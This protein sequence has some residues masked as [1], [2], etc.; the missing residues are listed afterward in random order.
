M[1]LYLSH[2]GPCPAKLNY[3][4][5]LYRKATK[6][7]VRAPVRALG[8]WSF[9]S[10]AFV[11]LPSKYISFSQVCRVYV[12]ISIYLALKSSKPSMNSDRISIFHD[13]LARP[14]FDLS[15][16]GDRPAARQ[17]SQKL[18]T[19][20]CNFTNLSIG[21]N[22]KCGCQRFCDRSEYSAGVTN[23]DGELEREKV[24]WCMCEHHA[25]FHEVGKPADDI[26][27]IPIRP[28]QASHGGDSSLP[29]TYRDTP[30][31]P[32]VALQRA[33]PSSF[34]SGTRTGEQLPTPGVDAEIGPPR[35]DVGT[36][37]PNFI[38]QDNGLPPI[39]SQ[40]LLSSNMNLSALMGPTLSFR[41]AKSREELRAGSGLIHDW[42]PHPIQAGSYNESLTDAA[43][44]LSGYLENA[45]FNDKLMTMETEKSVASQT[46]QA[47][48]PSSQGILPLAPDENAGHATSVVARSEMDVTNPTPTFHQI[49]PYVSDIHKH[50]A[51]K[52]TLKDTLQNHEDRLDH[53]E[54]ATHS[55][56]APTDAGNCDC[57]CDLLSH[58]H[59]KIECRMDRV[60]KALS[61]KRFQELGF[62]RGN[63]SVTSDNSTAM[64]STGHTEMYSRIDSRIEALEFRLGDLDGS[65]PP[66]ATNPWEFEVVFLPYGLDMNRVWS[67]TGNATQRNA[68]GTQDTA[69]PHMLNGALS[70]RFFSKAAT[71]NSWEHV[72][73]KS[74]PTSTVFTARACGIE[75]VVDKRLRSRG[76]VRTIQVKG[77]DA[78]HVQFAMFEAF[79]D[80]LQTM[81]S[82][83]SS[84][85]K[86]PKPLR[87]YREALGTSWI[88]MRKLHKD[89]QLRFLE[90]SEMLT[91]TL[92][93][94][95]FLAEISMQQSN[96]RRL[97][98][99][100]KDGYLQNGS[101]GWTWQKIRHLPLFSE[102]S[103][104]A[105]SS[106]NGFQPSRSFKP[107]Q[108][109]VHE[110]HWNW[111]ERLDGPV[112]H[113]TVTT[114]QLS[115]AIVPPESDR[116][117][118]SPTPSTSSSE[119]SPPLRSRTPYSEAL[120]QPISPLTER[121]LARPYHG[122]TTSMPTTVPI[123]FRPSPGSQGK[124]RITSFELQHERGTHSP[125]PFAQ[126]HSY[127]F[128]AKRQRTQ[129]PNRPRDTPRW[130]AEPPSP[131]VFEEE[132]EHKRG[133][134]PFAYA[135][136]H[137][138]A[139]YVYNDRR[140]M[141]NVP[142]DWG[143]D[144]EDSPTDEFE[145]D[146]NNNEDYMSDTDRAHQHEEE[147]WEG[148]NDLTADQVK[149]EEEDDN[150]IEARAFSDDDDAVSDTS[151]TPSEYPST[152][153]VAQYSGNKGTFEI[154]EDEAK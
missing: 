112:V 87:R 19:G 18:P 72:L 38:P 97:Y 50:Y 28:R 39:P 118:S 31:A 41:S 76:L 2:T 98:I 29:S 47:Q 133:M 61:N 35:S 130:S 20:A 8:L 107:S 75:N 49:L 23:A 60:E 56:A 96:I 78:Q 42:I 40:C 68:W 83:V 17:P 51:V 81:S 90:T 124:R 45:E 145:T 84:P 106:D 25:C 24:G 32:S 37:G 132:R 101:A 82:G 53:L 9:S 85:S 15:R 108:V 1:L 95:S 86:I 113:Q 105:A 142:N 134:T 150:N 121:N 64:T 110:P 152:H 128:S 119:Y 111:E 104:S 102:T 135:T 139:P 22:A 66:S 3:H 89:S 153:P 26:A 131:Y 99:T 11:F 154:H 148:V 63:G 67:R 34:N 138:N 144:N 48:K 30:K 137:S 88:P 109:Q 73:E 5:I 91:P 149:M 52:P 143:I 54:N 122:R 103:H 62:G 59:E 79:E 140:S 70:Q 33:A 58:K 21:N 80:I 125:S 27:P 117:E 6:C 13:S 147:D 46:N 123:N 93:T 116:G 55:C 7:C 127:S 57:D 69:S 77:P 115:L 16:Y 36:S 141:S 10:L 92:W 126:R 120:G 94:A 114:Q 4:S 74:Q 136:P 12:H 65:L 146:D 129:S 151:S 43:S 100:N 14:S 44:T 71:D